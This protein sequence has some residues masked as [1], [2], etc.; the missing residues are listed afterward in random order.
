ELYEP[1]A[2]EKGF[3]MRLNCAPGVLIRGDRHL[4]PQALANLLDN[5]LKYGASPAGES[6]IT[7]AVLR[8]GGRAV[9]EVGDRGPGIPER[10]R[11]RRGDQRA[12]RSPPSCRERLAY[13]TRRC[14]IPGP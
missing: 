10:A 13:R 14:A 4:L 12:V 6:E 3:A 7:V 5:A 1:V 9:L 11:E 2:E 8:E